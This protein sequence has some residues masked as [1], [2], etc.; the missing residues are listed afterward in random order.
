MRAKDRRRTASISGGTSPRSLAAPSVHAT[1]R[2]YGLSRL[3]RT[4]PVIKTTTATAIC[5]KPA[6]IDAL[7][8]MA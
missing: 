6:S 7:P 4:K 3:S 5:L 1:G 2:F 8:T